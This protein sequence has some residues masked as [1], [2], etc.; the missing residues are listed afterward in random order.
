ML[1]IV[2]HPVAVNPDRALETIAY[3]RGWAIVEF[4]RARKKVMKRTTAAVGEVVIA[5]R[6]EDLRSVDEICAVV[7]RCRLG[8]ECSAS[9]AGPG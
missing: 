4:S 9:N 6:D 7:V 2:G 5:P 1:E 3:H 8:A